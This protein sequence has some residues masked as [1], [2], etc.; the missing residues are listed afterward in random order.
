MNH[1]P[2]SPPPLPA[3]LYESPPV[4]AGGMVLWVVIGA[5]AFAFGAGELVWTAV[6][7]LGVGLFGLTVFLAQ[8]AA[9]RRGDRS[10]QR[11]VDPH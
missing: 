7:G 2:P 10:A 8:R 11:G 9:A 6:A 4:I 3:R 5:L 1:T